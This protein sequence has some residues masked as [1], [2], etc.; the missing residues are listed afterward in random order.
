MAYCYN[1]IIARGGWTRSRA[2]KVGGFPTQRSYI[3][4]KYRLKSLGGSF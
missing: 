4:C 1:H 3:T 2:Q